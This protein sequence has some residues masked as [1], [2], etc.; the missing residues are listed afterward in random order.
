MLPK[1]F[2]ILTDVECEHEEFELCD[3]EQS[4]ENIEA[5]L[6]ALPA[7]GSRLTVFAQDGTGSL[8]ALW[9]RPGEDD[10]ERAAVIYLGSEGDVTALAVEPGAFIDIVAARVSVDAEDDGC[11]LHPP[12][13]AEEEEEEAGEEV[14]V[15]F[16]QKLGRELRDPKEVVAE[17]RAAIT[18]LRE[19]VDANNAHG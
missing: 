14:A 11:T 16:A 6:G 3:P 5:W 1:A 8:F 10:I 18:D 4:D 15:A 2:D 13:E 9:L 7:E 19:W 12:E 17:A